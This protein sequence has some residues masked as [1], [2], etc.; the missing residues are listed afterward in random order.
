MQA[1]ETIRT[2][3]QW[4]NRNY[5]DI[6]AW[7]QMMVN[8]IRASPELRAGALAYYAKNKVDFINHWCDTVDPRNAGNLECLSDHAVPMFQRQEDLLTFVDECVRR[9]KTVWSRK[10]E[11]P[12]RLGHIAP[13]AVHQWRF[14][15]G[16]AIG[17]GSRKEQLVDKIGDMDYI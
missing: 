13:G 17:W 16:A 1:P 12:E 10:S 15:P 7:R 11:L 3:E 9:N 4:N 2:V 6:Y 14:S 5:T 8:A